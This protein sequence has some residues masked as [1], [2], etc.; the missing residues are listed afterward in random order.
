MQDKFIN[1][2]KFIIY[3]KELRAFVSECDMHEEIACILAIIKI[4]TFCVRF[5]C[6][7]SVCQ[8]YTFFVFPVYK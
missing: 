8:K 5:I 2:I 3:F 1:M 7:Y 4:I 6:V